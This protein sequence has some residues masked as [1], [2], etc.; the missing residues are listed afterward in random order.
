MKKIEYEKKCRI[1][2]EDGEILEIQTLKRNPVCI[3]IQCD[4]GTLLVDE[5]PIKKIDEIKMEKEHKTILKKIIK[6][7][8]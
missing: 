4:N 6:E 1:I 3:Q 8:K 5:I 7:K 2:L